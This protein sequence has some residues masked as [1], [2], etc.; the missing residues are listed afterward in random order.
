M[1]EA[2]RHFY[3]QALVENLPVSTLTGRQWMP[4]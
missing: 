1:E 4:P 3:V 2:M